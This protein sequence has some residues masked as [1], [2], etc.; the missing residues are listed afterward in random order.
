MVFGK[1]SSTLS[2]LDDKWA[3]WS[4]VFHCTMDYSCQDNVMRGGERCNGEL[5]NGFQ[6]LTRFEN[7]QGCPE[8]G[9]I[10]GPA[11]LDTGKVVFINDSQ[12][13]FFN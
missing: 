5:D 2:Q 11:H 7:G 4:Q 3:W 13:T 8:L 9:E 1:P 10:L 6:K 12:S